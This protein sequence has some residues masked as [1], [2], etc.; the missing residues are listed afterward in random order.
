MSFKIGDH[1][2]FW[3]LLMGAP[4]EEETG[5]R[6]RVEFLFL[7]GT[8]AVS[9]EGNGKKLCGEATHRIELS[10]PRPDALT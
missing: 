9:V 5:T 7:D 10:S 8:M 3:S 1:I 2:I 4:Y 6:A